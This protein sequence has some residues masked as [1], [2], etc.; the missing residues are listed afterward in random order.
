MLWDWSH[1]HIVQHAYFE[2][3][4]LISSVFF[5]L[6]KL[7][8]QIQLKVNATIK[9]KNREDMCFSV[10]RII[11]KNIITYCWCWFLFEYT[12][13]CVCCVYIHVIVFGKRNGELNLFII[14]LMCRAAVNSLLDWIDSTLPLLPFLCTH[15][16]H[17]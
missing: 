7:R 11:E 1:N 2:Y 3:V 10:A 14:E 8:N 4:H 6:C 5:A 9:S 13:A 16:T 15:Y 17:L 12:N